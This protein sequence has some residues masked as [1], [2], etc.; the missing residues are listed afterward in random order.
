MHHNNS[1]QYCSTETVLLI[2]PFLQTNITS[3]MWP[4]EIMDPGT[5]SASV[6]CRIVKIGWQ[7]M[8][9][10]NKC[11]KIHL[12]HNNEESGKSDL[13]SVSGTRSPPKVNQFFQL[14]GTIITP[15]FN[16]I[17]CVYFYSNTPHSRTTWITTE[18]A[19]TWLHDLH[20]GRRN[21][22]S[23]WNT[24]CRTQSQ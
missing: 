22:N 24:N 19:T 4:I 23:D 9:N 15:S 20:L 5:L 7:L 8:R 3:Q 21:K 11:P 18:K 6:I 10:A 17:C 16:D 13:E 2:F 14:V 12:F 1:T